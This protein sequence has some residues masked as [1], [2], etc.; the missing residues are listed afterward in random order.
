MTKITDYPHVVIVGA[1][2]TGMTLA[3]RYRELGIPFVVLEKASEVGGVWRDNVYPGISLDTAAS[4]YCL[5]FAEK[6]DWNF[7]HPPGGEL[8]AY[9]RTVAREHR[10]NEHIRFDTEVR[11]C[12]WDH[13]QWNVELGDGSTIRTDMVV[14]ATGFLRIPS[15][16]NFPGRE[17]FRGPQFHSAE[18]DE[19]FDPKGKRVAVIGTGSSGIQI[20]TALAQ[21]EARCEVTQ[22]VR[23]PQW[24]HTRPNHRQG[25]VERWFY[26]H[27]VRLARKIHTERELKTKLRDPKLLKNGDWRRFPGPARDEAFKAFHDDL[28]KHIKDPVLREKMT[29]P[30]SPGCKRIPLAPGYYAAI[31]RPN[32]STVRGGVERITED[33]VIDSHGDFHEVDA[34]VYATG[35]DGHAY[36][37]PIEIYGATGEELG[38]RWSA[39]SPQVYLSL[40]TPDYPNLFVTHGPYSAINSIPIPVTTGEMVDY[41]VKVAVYVASHEVAV[42]PS[43][44]AAT[45]YLKWVHDA[46]DGTIWAGDC[47]SWYKTDAGEAI[48]WPFGRAEHTEMLSVFDPNDFVKFE[49]TL[50]RRVGTG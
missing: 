25:P 14:M 31:Q 18:W 21:P 49:A 35:F 5:Q 50:C 20:T 41:T 9:L 48:L 10:L 36:F 27:F 43:P 12:R 45:K 37:K 7:Q 22:F 42:A 29:P 28:R 24:I 19:D 4:G 11:T 47:D 2:L 23:T 44:E 39:G 8:Q 3:H 15:I 16:P 30:D 40:M 1:G 32:V 34:I 46:M 6:Y 38:A 26:R 17:T 33:G 13:G